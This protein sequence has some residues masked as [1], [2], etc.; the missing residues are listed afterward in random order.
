M[1]TPIK[2]ILDKHLSIIEDKIATGIVTCDDFNNLISKTMIGETTPEAVRDRLRRRSIVNNT[3]SHI[4]NQTG[5]QPLNSP[6]LTKRVQP[7][8]TPT[9]QQHHGINKAAHRKSTRTQRRKA[10]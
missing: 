8:R 2:D 5:H 1:I 6:S 3:E 7:K 9:S 10:K 4:D